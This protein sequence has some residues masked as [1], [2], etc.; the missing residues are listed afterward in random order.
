[1]CDDDGPEEFMERW[2]EELGERSIEAGDSIGAEWVEGD[3]YKQN[4]RERT[5]LYVKDGTIYLESD[6][7]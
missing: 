7:E 2:K 5:K 3:D 6:D 4:T 1:M